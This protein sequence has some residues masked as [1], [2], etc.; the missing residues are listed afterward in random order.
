[1]NRTEK[2]IALLQPKD[3]ISKLYLYCLDCKVETL[4]TKVSKE[5]KLSKQK[6][7]EIKLVDR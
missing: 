2:L 5:P 1:M 7:I 6:I 4:I 3:Y